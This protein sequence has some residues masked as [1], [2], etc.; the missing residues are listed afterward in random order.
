MAK[1][2]VS[3]DETVIVQ[4]VNV[5]PSQPFWEQYQNIIMYA[6]GAVAVAVLGW[7][8]YKSMI[9]GPKQQEAV[10][11][12]W[13]A[14][15]QFGRD[16][17]QLALENPGG[18]FDGFLTIADKYSGTP[19]GNLANYYSGICYL[20]LGDF[21]NAIKFLEDYD[22]EGM[23]LPAMKVGA[24]GD[25]YAEKKD[26][27]KALDYYEKA[28]NATENDVVAAYYLKKLGMLYQYQDKHDKAREAYERLRKE[29]PNQGSADWRDVEKYIYR[30][31]VGK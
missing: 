12:M 6:L 14:E 20:H 4:E 2:K 26:F 16:S 5:A 28:S 1:R 19:A 9:V 3:P 21:D 22:A 7:W 29:F 31:S 27:D 13:Q 23:L 25:A 24:L 11:S 8:L 17:F 10:A 15:A 30:A 18:G